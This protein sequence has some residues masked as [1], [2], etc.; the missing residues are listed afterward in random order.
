MTATEVLMLAVGLTLGM[1][2]SNL[3]HTYWAAQDA[4]RA[5]E[6]HR[7]SMRRPRCPSDTATGDSAWLAFAA[8]AG[9][10]SGVGGRSS[11]ATSISASPASPGARP[12]SRT[13]SFV[14]PG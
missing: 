7:Q 9:S 8:S 2:L 3:L 5:R 13:A 10:G 11:S 1:Q 4:R 14:A 12:V 6:Q